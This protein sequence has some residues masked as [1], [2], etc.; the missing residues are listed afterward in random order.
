MA[1]TGQLY[2]DAKLEIDATG[3]QV[4]KIQ[5]W[6]YTMPCRLVH[7]RLYV[8]FFELCY[9]KP[10]TRT[11]DNAKIKPQYAGSWCSRY[12]VGR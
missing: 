3:K 10:R 9:T 2:L 8:F 7:I 12:V 1:Y 5:S 4:L 11:G 6:G